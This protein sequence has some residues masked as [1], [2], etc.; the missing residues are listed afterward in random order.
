MRRIAA[1]RGRKDAS[2][3]KK[4]LG[5]AFVT[6]LVA[7]VSACGG[8]VSGADG[9]ADTAAS[10]EDTLRQVEVGALP[11]VT[12]SP[13]ALGVEKGF[14]EEEGLDVELEM[15]Q[16]GAALVPAVVSGQQQFAFSN[17]V[18]LLLA[19]A[20]GLPLTIVAAASSAGEDPAPIDEALVVPKG[21]P[22]DSVSDLAGKSL[23]VN[24]LNNIVEVANRVTIEAAGL[25]S[26]SVDFVEVPFP[27]MP[28]ALAN[29]NV[30]AA[31]VA[32][33][34]LTEAVNAGATIIAHPYREVKPDIHVSSWFTT[35]EFANQ[36]PE[37]IDKFLR[38]LEESRKYAAAHEDEV[39]Q[40]IPE[41]LGIDPK[42][43]EKI[44]LGNWPAGLPTEESLNAWREAA[45]DS[46]VIKQGAV[47]DVGVL[48]HKN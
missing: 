30:D 48:L 2:L 39:R 23:A 27:D 5:G 42:V 7:G 35:E 31:H 13:I 8:G 26:D 45:Q 38:A 1:S 22:V 29:G 17:N 34:F 32:E 47:P 10:D 41:F 28:A 16:G 40:F 44:A 14:F 21:S 3:W 15:G 11:I 37:V 6:A 18:S 43:A 25:D 24:T 46:G 9:G 12:L 20:Q 36:N 4:S 19:R 33:P